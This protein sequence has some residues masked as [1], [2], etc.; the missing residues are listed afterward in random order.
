MKTIT[1]KKA[2]FFLMT[3]LVFN[4]FG[5]CLSARYDSDESIPVFFEPKKENVNPVEAYE[6]IVPG[7][8]DLK[9]KQVYD[10]YFNPVSWALM[11]AKGIVVQVRENSAGTGFSVEVIVGCFA[12]NIKLNERYNSK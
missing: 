3:F 2:G 10:K 6:L 4:N 11:K 5:Y 8:E 9:W 1:L 12:G 7:I